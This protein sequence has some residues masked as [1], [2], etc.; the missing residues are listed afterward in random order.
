[1]KSNFEIGELCYITAM[2]LLDLY[3]GLGIIIE[4]NLLHQRFRWFSQEKS[5][6][7]IMYS[8]DWLGKL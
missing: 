2:G 5:K 1:M 6:D 3:R 8:E 4:Y 7:Y